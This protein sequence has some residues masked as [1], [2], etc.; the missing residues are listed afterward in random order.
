MNY[1]YVLCMLYVR[2]SMLV[3]MCMLDDYVYV[4]WLCVCYTFMCMFYVCVA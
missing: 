4:L 1:V 2:C 3:L